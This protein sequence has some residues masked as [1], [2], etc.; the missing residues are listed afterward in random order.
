MESMRERKEQKKNKTL[1]TTQAASSSSS[2]SSENKGSDLEMASRSAPF[3]YEDV[4]PHR[5]AHDGNID[6][7]AMVSSQRLSDK[8]RRS[9]SSTPASASAVSSPMFGSVTR[10][11]E[12][13]RKI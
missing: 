7:A 4:I 9:L 8:L 12:V 1:A 5:T 3:N 13:G 11:S 10:L 2:S 6:R